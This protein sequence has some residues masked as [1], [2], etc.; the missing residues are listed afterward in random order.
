MW[1]NSP[2]L[3]S[4]R[5]SSQ[6]ISNHRHRK[7]ISVPQSHSGFHHGSGY[8]WFFFK[9]RIIFAFPKL[10]SYL[11]FFSFTAKWAKSVWYI[12]WLIILKKKTTKM[13][14]HTITLA[15]IKPSFTVKKHTRTERL[16]QSDSRQF[17]SSSPSWHWR[18]PSQICCLVTQREPSHLR[19]HTSWHFLSS[20]PSGQWALPSHTWFLSMHLR[21]SS[22]R[23][24][25]E[26]AKGHSISVGGMVSECISMCHYTALHLMTITCNMGI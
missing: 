22:H 15:W 12:T 20:E 14:Y 7:H 8:F 21:R 5:S 10:Q 6:I 17:L 24:W 11:R 23:K 25:A 9:A 2:V 18:T 26:E 3:Q 16:L 19:S 13:V 4:T 1:R